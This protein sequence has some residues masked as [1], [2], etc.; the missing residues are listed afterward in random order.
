MTIYAQQVSD[1]NLLTFA[2]QMFKSELAKIV[3]EEK[4]DQAYALLFGGL[5]MRL[6]DGNQTEIASIVVGYSHSLLISSAYLNA[7]AALN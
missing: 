6:L 4:V 5:M 7:I 1:D 2:N 3:G